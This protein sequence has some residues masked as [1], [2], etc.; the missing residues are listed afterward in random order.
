MARAAQE[1]R[2]GEDGQRVR[3]HAVGAAVDEQRRPQRRALLVLELGHL[4][5]G[6][7]V[8]R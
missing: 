3:P 1:A 4:Q 7:H 2:A 5:R 8:G 6:G